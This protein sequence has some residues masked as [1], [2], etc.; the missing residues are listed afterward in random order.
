[1]LE[2][3]ILKQETVKQKIIES[4]KYGLGRQII[5]LELD[6]LNIIE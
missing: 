2:N 3:F 5:N 6:G 4:A 1:M